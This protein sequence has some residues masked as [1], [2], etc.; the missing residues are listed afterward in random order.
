MEE[1]RPIYMLP[2]ADSL[3]TYRH[4]QI[5]SKVME[6]HLPCKWKQK[7]GWSSNTYIGQN[8]L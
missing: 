6:K 3:Q 8:R 7:E 4:M 5:E 2:T 1:T